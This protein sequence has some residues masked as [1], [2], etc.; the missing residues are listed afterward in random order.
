[1]PYPIHDRSD[2][3]IVPLDPSSTLPGY[4]TAWC[5]EMDA[6]V[7]EGQPF[8]LVYP[9]SE[10]HEGHEDRRQRGLW[11]KNNKER[12]AAI[13]LA[14]IVVEPDAAKRAELEMVFPNLARAFGTL[15]A[16]CASRGEAEALGRHPLSG[17]Q[18]R[19]GA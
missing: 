7:A 4:A 19:T 18:L 1:M 6:L 16:A 5:E 8:V 9:A 11:L 2:F 14:F 3:P 13:C 15:Q 17:G 10:R 12:L